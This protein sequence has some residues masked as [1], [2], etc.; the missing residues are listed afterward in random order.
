MPTTPTTRYSN[1]T[2]YQVLQEQ[3]RLLACWAAED[4]ARRTRNAARLA[5]LES[6]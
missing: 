4:A 1:M 5:A 2:A 6:V 3:N